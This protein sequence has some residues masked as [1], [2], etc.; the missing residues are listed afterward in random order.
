MVKAKPFTSPC[1]IIN[2][3]CDC[4]RKYSKTVNF[5]FC[6]ELYYF[7]TLAKFLA[8]TLKWTLMQ[9]NNKAAKIKRNHDLHC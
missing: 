2:A 7:I 6:F 4:T 3:K 1:G 9:G 8:K 5:L